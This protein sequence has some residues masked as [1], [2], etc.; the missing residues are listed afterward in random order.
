MT[1]EMFPD[2]LHKEEKKKVTYFNFI[3]VIPL[4]QR[5]HEKSF[6]FVCIRTDFD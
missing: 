1:A 2:Y 4:L 5:H 6:L 3:N